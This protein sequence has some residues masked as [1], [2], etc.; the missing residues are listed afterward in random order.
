M[1]ASRNI[2]EHMESATTW[3]TTPF[4]LRPSASL[5][6]ATFAVVAVDVVNGGR[7][8][9]VIHESIGGASGSVDQIDRS[10][11]SSPSKTS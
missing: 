6:G 3:S 10:A 4:L 5:D 2:R 7:E 11:G 1:I 8:R 9:V